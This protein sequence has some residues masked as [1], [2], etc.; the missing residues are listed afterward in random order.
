MN[1]GAPGQAHYLQ[2]L[3]G[4]KGGAGSAA[5]ATQSGH[6]SSAKA[7]EEQGES[8]KTEASEGETGGRVNTYA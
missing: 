1:V 8:P 2:Q 4:S 5:A 3:L 7:A 6:A